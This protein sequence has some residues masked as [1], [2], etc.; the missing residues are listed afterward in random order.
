MGTYDA[1][2][3]AGRFALIALVLWF[4]AGCARSR[5][6]HAPPVPPVPVYAPPNMWPVPVVGPRVTSEFGDPRGGGRFHA[7][8]DIG[9]PLDTPV[10]ATADG[11]VTFAGTQGSY[12]TLVV[13]R[14]RAPFDTAYAH[15]S[16]AVVCVGQQVLR[17]QVIARSGCSGNATGPHLHYEVRVDG[18][19]V[20]PRPYLPQ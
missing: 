11:V 1:W 3:R 12:G 9:V 10:M 16:A 13:L 8:I 4:G 20:N 17:G 15:L 6:E 19:A 5:P 18:I 14:H 2:M 7:G